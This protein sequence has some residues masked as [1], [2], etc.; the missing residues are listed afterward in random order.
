MSD[1]LVT[2]ITF[3]F[4]IPR[5]C[6]ATCVLAIWSVISILNSALGMQ[7]EMLSDAPAFTVG[8]LLHTQ[9]FDL[10]RCC[11][12]RTTA[13]TYLSGSDAGPHSL[14]CVMLSLSYIWTDQS[15]AF[16]FL[17]LKMLV[18][19]FWEP[20]QAVCSTN[21]FSLG[22]KTE[23]TRQSPFCQHCHGSTGTTVYPK[24]NGMTECQTG[25]KVC[26]FYLKWVDGRRWCHV[27][28]RCKSTNGKR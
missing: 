24:V 15:C 25:R 18:C 28:H 16:S 26:L 9:R 1:T 14:G 11:F 4:D 7:L 17:F 2:C 8:I 22:D 19:Q 21:A 27:T 10:S 13:V 20:C 5:C 6:S 23:M 12:I 3:T